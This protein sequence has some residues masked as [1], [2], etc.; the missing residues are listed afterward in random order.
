MEAIAAQ[1]LLSGVE[2]V[3]IV[4]AKR[5]SKLEIHA[6]LIQGT[7][8]VTGWPIQAE[9]A[10]IAAYRWQRAGAATDG[11]SRQNGGVKQ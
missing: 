5:G 9:F 10:P 7:L 1:N 11:P 3:T 4:G 6:W 2:C 8:Q